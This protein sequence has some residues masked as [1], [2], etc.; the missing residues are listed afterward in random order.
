MIGYVYIGL[1]VLAV[2][3][4]IY[5]VVRVKKKWDGIKH[6]EKIRD[7]L[8][9]REQEQYKEEFGGIGWLGNLV[10][11]IVTVVVGVSLIPTIQ[12]QVQEGIATTNQSITPLSNTL[13]SITP[14]F[15]ALGIVMV[16]IV[17]ISSSMRSAGL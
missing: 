14:V 12:S 8:T 16:G 6:Y 3:L 17:V 5:F 10:G 15:F 13:I 9:T 2:V 4:A 11:A 7:K 1:N